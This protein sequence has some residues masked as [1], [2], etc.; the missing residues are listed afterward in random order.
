MCV[1]C[2]AAATAAAA[3][4]CVAVVVVAVVLQA[5]GKPELVKTAAT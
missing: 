3:E 4:G 1:V 5:W 2:G